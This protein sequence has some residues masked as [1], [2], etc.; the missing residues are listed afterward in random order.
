MAMRPAEELSRGC[1]C[2][3]WCRRAGYR[4]FL[5]DADRDRC[6]LYGRYGIFPIEQPQTRVTPE[7]DT[8]NRC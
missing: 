3:T 8:L 7:R 5:P 6:H 4:R 1:R 2:A